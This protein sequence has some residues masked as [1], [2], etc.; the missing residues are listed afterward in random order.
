MSE[1]RRTAAGRRR[2]P[3][4][5]ANDRRQHRAG[6]PRG[7]PCRDARRCQPTGDCRR[8]IRSR[9]NHGDGHAD[10]SFVYA[11]ATEIAGALTKFAVI[12]TKSTVPVGTGDE[13]ER[14]IRIASGSACN[15]SWC[16]ASSGGRSRKSTPSTPTGSSCA[17]RCS[18]R[19]RANRSRRRRPPPRRSCDPRSDRPGR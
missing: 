7:P 11:A 2:S 6:H 19:P 13:I 8:S 9:S 18:R 16:G 17:G 5:C 4:S 12:V 14:I 10:L 1:S 3:T 15:S